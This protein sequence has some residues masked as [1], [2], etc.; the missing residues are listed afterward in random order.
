MIQIV[1]L[2]KS[3]VSSISSVIEDW[4]L[5]SDSSFVSVS[6]VPVSHWVV[7]RSGSGFSAAGGFTFSTHW[8]TVDSE[9]ICA[10]RKSLKLGEANG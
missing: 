2:S 5:E 8:L 4:S 7:Y 3:D 9:S 1:I 10:R 6:V